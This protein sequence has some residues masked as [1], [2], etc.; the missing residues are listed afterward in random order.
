MLIEVSKIKLSS[1]TVRLPISPVWIFFFLQLP[2]SGVHLPFVSFVPSF[3]L[4]FFLSTVSIWQ[5]DY[6]WFLYSP[7][8]IP[9]SRSTSLINPIPCH[10]LTSIN[11]FLIYCSITSPLLPLPLSLQN[12]IPLWIWSWDSSLWPLHAALSSAPLPFWSTFTPFL[13]THP[14][15]LFSGYSLLIHTMVPLL[16]SDSSIDPTH[17]YDYFSNLG[18]LSDST[19]IYFLIHLYFLVVFVLWI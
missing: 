8:L 16:L 3:W 11:L 6:F 10:S 2:W 4:H 1:K 7:Y 14:S 17:S 12:Q 15:G 18:Y 5:V 19:C 9:Y 13:P